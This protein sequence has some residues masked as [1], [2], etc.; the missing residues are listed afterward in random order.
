MK[1]SGECETAKE[2]QMS[3]SNEPREVVVKNHFS[4]SE[5]IRISCEKGLTK[6]S[7]K[8]ECD[9]NNILKKYEKSGILEHANKYQGQYADVT[10]TVDYQTALNT[11]MAAKDMFMSLPASIRTMFDNDPHEFLEF[12]QDPENQEA[13]IEMGL[14]ERRPAA[15]ESGEEAPEGK[16]A[17]TPAAEPKGSPAAS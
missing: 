8:D 3:M 2:N 1:L 14:A 15:P 13:M 5:P 10:G 17:E 16:P 6:Q 9:I 4:P 12:A 7:F 11:V